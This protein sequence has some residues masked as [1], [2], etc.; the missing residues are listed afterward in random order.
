MEIKHQGSGLSKSARG[1]LQ[2]LNLRPEESGRT[3]LMLA[4]YTATCVGLTWS[5]ASTAALFLDRYGAESLPWIY[6]ASAVMGSLLG[7][8]YSWLEKWLPLRRLIVAIALLMAIPLFGLRFGLDIIYVAGLTV[9]LLRLW[10]EACHVLNEM[11]TSITANQL[12][13]I[14]EI[15]RTYPLV[16]SGILMADVISGF[17]LPLLLVVFKLNNVVLVSSVM[18]SLLPGMLFYIKPE[19]SKVFLNSFI[20]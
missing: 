15:K 16:S 18:I 20:V 3:L 2:L 12:F 8:L 13:N 7:V 4:F 17:S 1:L 11:N 19:N 5:E 10:V 6:I 14:R 9:F